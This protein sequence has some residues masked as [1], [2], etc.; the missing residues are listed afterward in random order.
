M[1]AFCRDA[2]PGPD[3]RGGW[4][5]F[6]AGLLVFGVA[7]FAGLVLQLVCVVAAW[8]EYQAMLRCLTGKRLLEPYPVLLAVPC[9]PRVGVD[10]ID[11]HVHVG[12]SGILVGD[13]DAL[14]FGQFKVCAGVGDDAAL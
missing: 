1:C 2:A 4:F 9:L 3:H 14:V 5:P 6:P 10:S 7:G 12:V 8:D 13:D 11:D